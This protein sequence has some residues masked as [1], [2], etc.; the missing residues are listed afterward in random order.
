MT[1]QQ[2]ITNLL[3]INRKSETR[4]LRYRSL[5]GRVKDQVKRKRPEMD[6]R[7]TR[8]HDKA[9]KKVEVESGLERRSL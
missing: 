5:G 7:L 1:V 8:K 9:I 6:P 3:K 4:S 2:L